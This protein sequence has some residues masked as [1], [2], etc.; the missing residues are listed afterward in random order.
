MGDGRILQINVTINDC[1]AAAYEL[2]KGEIGEGGERLGRRR[3]VE[4]AANELAKL[5]FISRPKS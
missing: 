4:M 3:R 1:P 2:K 5:P